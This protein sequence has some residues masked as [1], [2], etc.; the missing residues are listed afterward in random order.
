MFFSFTSGVMA[1][2]I[3]DMSFDFSLLRRSY[4]SMKCTVH[5]NLLLTLLKSCVYPLLTLSI[6]NV[7]PLLTLS[8]A[9]PFWA[10]T[11]S[12]LVNLKFQN[13]CLSVWSFLDVRPLSASPPSMLNLR[14][15]GMRS[16]PSQL[17]S[18]PDVCRWVIQETTV[19]SL[20]GA[21][22]ARTRATLKHFVDFF[23]N[24]LR[25]KNPAS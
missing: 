5:V 6:A 13:P 16:P 17:Q 18:I 24:L 7:N 8:R 23:V 4:P 19:I 10:P 22:R 2:R 25:D 14:L 11:L 12:P 15:R 21:A 9:H 3:G 1:A 20:S